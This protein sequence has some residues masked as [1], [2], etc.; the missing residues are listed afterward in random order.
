M[1]RPDTESDLPQKHLALPD[2]AGTAGLA[3]KLAE[4]ARAGDCFALWGD[5]GAGK[6][7]F[8]RAFLRAAGVTEDVPS[9]TF[10]IV[11]PYDTGIGP[12]AH[13][14][15]YRIESAADLDEVGFDMALDDG[16]VLVEWPG[17]AGDRLPGDR[18]DIQFTLGPAG[19]RAAALTGRGSWR[20]RLAGLNL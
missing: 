7:E 9:P 16:I 8:A 2:L 11:Q 3:R 15:L 5:L 6:T 12:I 17:H 14:D 10:A 20:A 19:D 4:T 18:L 1:P 13:F